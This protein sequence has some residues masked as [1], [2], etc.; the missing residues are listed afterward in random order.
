MKPTMNPCVME[1]LNEYGNFEISW[2]C[3]M[4]GTKIKIKKGAVSNMMADGIE[5]HLVTHRIDKDG[6]FEKPDNE[7]R[8]I[9]MTEFQK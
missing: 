4:C 9:P 3:D 5:R 1:F 6:W 2:K 7:N 8:D